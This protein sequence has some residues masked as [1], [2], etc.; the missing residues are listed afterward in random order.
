MSNSEDDQRDAAQRD[1]K[2]LVASRDLTR[3][4]T[5]GA[6]EFPWVDELIRQYNES[7]RV[8]TICPHLQ[9]A[10]TQP[11]VWLPL[12][13][14]YLACSRPECGRVVVAELERRLG[15]TLAEEPSRCSIC[16]RQVMTRGV[17]VGGGT[18]VISGLLCGECGADDLGDG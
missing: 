8:K 6:G 1:V 13:P 2:K 3:E 7:P 17:S 15:H 18:T 9:K 5:H 16:G 12:I 10:P 11:S 14:D 4:T